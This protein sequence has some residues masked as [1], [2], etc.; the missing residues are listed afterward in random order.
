[1]NNA[2]VKRHYKS[3]RLTVAICLIGVLTISALSY[4]I[5]NQTL[6]KNMDRALEDAVF[7]VQ[8][9]VI[10][11]NAAVRVLSGSTN[12]PAYLFY[13]EKLGRFLSRSRDVSFAG[14]ATQKSSGETFFLSSGMDSSNH[15]LPE[16]I[17]S[18]VLSL[19]EAQ[20]EE[21]QGGPEGNSHAVIRHLYLPD[22]GK[23][24]VVASFVR[25]ETGST[26]IYYAGQQLDSL[27]S[28]QY[29]HLLLEGAKAL[30]S[31]IAI[32]L[33]IVLYT[34]AT[35]ETLHGLNARNKKLEE[36]LQ[37]LQ[38]TEKKLREV[39]RDN[40]RFNALTFGRE[41][42]IIRLKSEVNQLLAQMQRE[43]R[44]NVDKMD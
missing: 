4:Y 26:L 20:Q 7:A 33:S 34:A 32:I 31:I 23:I 38:G 6:H 21:P 28:Q 42:R 44:Y 36:D 11:D 13:L 14:I 17:R 43:K 9:I 40:E 18:A 10:D 39:I 29:A 3:F 41:E 15:E 37:L 8:E 12:A 30:F 24:H 35:K 22:T 1:M 25:T 16:N 27:V 5:E 19:P 2:L